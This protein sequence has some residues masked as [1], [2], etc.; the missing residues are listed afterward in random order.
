MKDYLP[1]ISRIKGVNSFFIVD[2]NG[3]VLYRKFYSKMQAGTE[4]NI[5]K[6]IAACGSI[7]LA[8]SPRQFRYA[9]F[10]RQNNTQVLIFPF[11]RN[12]LTVVAETGTQN[13]GTDLIAD[14]VF[15]ILAKEMHK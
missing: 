14:E 6:T 9:A 1:N 3:N 7:Y 15:S 2:A 11:G 13:P 10:L 4:K 8:I 5:S 12:L